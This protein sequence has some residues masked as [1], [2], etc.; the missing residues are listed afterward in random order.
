MNKVKFSLKLFTIF[1]LA[2]CKPEAPLN[3]PYPFAGK[4][5]KTLYASFAERPKHLDPVR[6]YSSNEYAI[7]GQVYE[8]PLQYHYLKR[9]YILE[10]LTL[11]KMPRVR[12]FNAANEEIPD[13]SPVAE[14]KYSEYE[15]SLK[16][17]IYFQPHP[18]FSKNNAE[19]IFYPIQQKQ[20]S[21]LFKN[22]KNLTLRELTAADY[23]YQIK[24]M[25]N[26]NL[27]SPIY[28]VM[29]KYIVGLK[30]LR[31]QIKQHKTNE[32]LDLR[33]LALEGVR[34]IDKYTYQIRINGKYPQF[35]FWLAMP[36]FAPIPWEAD[37]FYTQKLLQDKN[38]NLDWYPV[39]TGPFMLTLN[40]PNSKM[41]LER[42]PNFHYETYPKESA[43]E[44]SAELIKD[45]GKAL[46]FVDK[47]IFS[48]EKENIPEWNKFLQGYYDASG[49]NSDSFDQAISIS[50]IGNA[51][52]TPYMQEKGIQ[53]KTSVATS[54]FYLG[55]NMLDPVVGGLNAKA[56]KLRQAVSIA[57]D[58][59]EYI[60]IFA[61]GRGIPAQSPLPP[62]IFGNLPGV[63][64][65]NPVVY[66][67]KN[68][69]IKRKSIDA[70]RRLLAEAGY[71]NGKDA[72]TGEQ[73]VLNFDSTGSGPDSKSIADWY[74]KQFAKLNIQLVMRNTDYN[75]FQEKIRKGK[76]QIFVWGWN[77]D[78]PDPENFLFLLY[79]PNAKVEGGGEN[80]VNYQNPEF[81][82]LFAKM[83]NMENSPERLLLIKEMLAILQEDAPWIWGMHPKSFG[84]YHSW[85]KNRKPNLMANNTLKYVRIDP[86]LRHEKQLEWN[87]PV[88][89]P[90]LLLALVFI[91]LLTPAWISYKKREQ[92]TANVHEN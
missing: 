27:H 61:N 53:L 31:T 88:F 7:I 90:L 64:G 17:G 18:A 14:I 2:A 80:A 15:L 84:L 50:D 30:E 25:A 51:E 65:M 73:L 5:D 68:N 45:A 41:I 62:G 76:A 69:K 91:V 70:A 52:L 59:E 79:G 9:P 72:K 28:G 67:W 23:V 26:P 48:L 11:T 74:R 21:G 77:A 3:N 36:F 92:Q 47:V 44:D 63:A 60:S 83:Q 1:I 49:I 13:D 10:P 86:K 39:G 12:Y 16:P 42:N 20:I 46:P 29:Q 78:Y 66:E 22:N 40:D 38:I 87:R 34:V 33:Q 85:Y 24:R 8:P 58:Y 57:F 75:R 32:W 71:P 43:I 82:L 35:K 6:S 37:R 19:Y 81:D 54:T 4:N 56:K 55:F 89:W